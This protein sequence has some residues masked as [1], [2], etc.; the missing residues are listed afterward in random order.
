MKCTTQFPPNDNEFEECTVESVAGDSFQRSDGWSFGVDKDWPVKPTVGA[1]AR[2][3]GRGIGY[4]VRGLF[5][6]G[7]KAFYRTEVQQYEHDA[8]Q[9]AKI[10]C[11]RMDRFE[12]NKAAM[13]AKY[14]ALPE[15]FRRRIDRF[16]AGCEDFRWRYEEYEMSVCEDA[17][18]IAQALKTEDAI[19]KFKDLP[20]ADQLKAVPG[21]F[22]GHSGN[23]FG[24]A[25]A[26]ARLFIRDPELVARY[27][28]ALTPLVGCEAYGCTHAED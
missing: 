4:T 17:V 7:Q 23:S 10:D 6:D 25:V 16:R 27:H 26:L 9:L 15:P 20:W 5:I 22:E 3:Y 28:G 24:C 1:V 21:L 19:V 11:E 13:D 8:E 2:F 14:A 18:R 12:E